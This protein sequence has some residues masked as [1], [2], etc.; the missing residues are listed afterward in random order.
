MA[1][2]DRFRILIIEDEKNTREGLEKALCLDYD[3]T[4]AEDGV[5]GLEILRR[6][7]FDI[8]LTDLRMPGIDGM[9][10]TRQA[11]QIANAPLIIML[12]AY[13]SIEVAVEAMKAGAYDYLTKP[14]NLDNLELLIKRG[15]E[16]RHLSQENKRLR[17]ELNKAQETRMIGEAPCMQKVFDDIRQMASAKTT[18][19][20]TG[21]SGTGKELV[22]DSLHCFSNR[23]EKPF[24][25]VHCAA[26]N[27]NLLESELF[28]HEKGAFTGATERKIGRLE[29]ADGGTVFLDEIGEID[30]ATQIKLLRVLETKVFERV[31]G[32]TPIKVDVR[33]I[34]AT[35]RDL[36]NECTLGNFREDLY[37]RLS[38]LKIHLP[39]LRERTKDVVLLLNH[40][41]EHFTMENGKRISG[42]T[43]DAMTLLCA[44]SWPGNVRELRNIVERM[45]VMS[46]GEVL[47][48]S[49]IPA[50]IRQALVGVSQKTEDPETLDV[51]TNERHLVEQ[52][53]IKCDNNVTKAAQML[54][55]SRRT[56]HRKLKSYGL[57]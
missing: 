52:A 25:I 54:G 13:G 39:P 12:T 22:A 56:L 16:K 6:Q 30:T 1:T 2:S 42:I 7:N 5:K 51:T 41:L 53:L 15:I 44:Y 20:V 28:G 55:M 19:L 33:I 14:I 45:V 3:V 36:K 4:L 11:S 50:D 21:E 17:D 49:D 27:A 23:K 32:T 9:E 8:A 48:I 37:Y 29:K 31:G 46:P 34:C 10:F 57:R 24:V 47:S 38:I 40:Y 26:L 35:N 43:P 18:V